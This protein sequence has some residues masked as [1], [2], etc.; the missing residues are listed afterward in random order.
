MNISSIL[1]GIKTWFYERVMCE[2][3]TVT[4][5]SSVLSVYPNKSYR[6]VNSTNNM[7]MMLVPPPASSRQ[8]FVY[9]YHL[10]FLSASTGTTTFACGP[11]VIWDETPTI[12]AGKAYEV[13]IIYNDGY[14]L[15]T[16]KEFG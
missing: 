13:S 1:S 15:G 8:N 2:V 4:D 5:T 10:I 3:V 9:H 16:I 12:N 7:R 11:T 14:Y 6:V